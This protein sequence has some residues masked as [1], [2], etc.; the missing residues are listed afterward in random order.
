[1]LFIQLIYSYATPLFD[2]DLFFIGFSCSHISYY[3][4]LLDTHDT[5]I[6]FLLF[7]FV[8]VFVVSTK[9]VT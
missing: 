5:V 2:I 4:S 8:V 7:C 6:T 1:M 9:S 3:F